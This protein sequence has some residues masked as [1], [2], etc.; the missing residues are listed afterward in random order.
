MVFVKGS[1]PNNKGN[2]Q[3]AAWILSHRDYDGDGCLTY[4]YKKCRG[5]GQ[6]Q[7]LGKWFYAH[8]FMCELVN[9]PAPSPKHQTA[10]TCGKGH[11]GCVNPRHLVWKTPSENQLDRRQ[12]GTAMLNPDGQ[13]GRITAEQRR[14]IRSLRGRETQDV[15]ASKFGISRRHVRRIQ[16]DAQPSTQGTKP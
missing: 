3:A 4:P 9:G 16:A 10:H 1:V 2:G 14:A 8:R 13:R 6:F 12:H 15:V 7:H 11:E 5:Y